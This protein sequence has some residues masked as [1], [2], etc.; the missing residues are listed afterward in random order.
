MRTL[1]HAMIP[2][3][4]MVASP[5]LSDTNYGELVGDRSIVFS[6]SAAMYTA[7]YDTAVVV[8]SPMAGTP[9]YRLAAVDIEYSSGGMSSTWMEGYCDI[10]GETM[11]GYIPLSFLAFTHQEL[12]D[13]SMLLFGVPS[14][15]PDEGPFIGV[16]KVVSDGEVLWRTVFYPPGSGLGSDHYGYGVTSRLEGSGS[17]RGIEDLVMLSFVYEACGFENRDVL[18]GWT[19]DYL[20]NLIS[21]SRMAE[22]GIFHYTEELVLPDPQGTS[23]VTLVIATEEEFDE[24][25]LEY[26][27]TAVDTTYYWWSGLELI[28]LDVF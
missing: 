5:V 19:G 11:H 17:L 13:G 1:L 14:R 25:S 24:G 22:A 15:M 6:E 18:L 2:V 12:S 21:V 4:L 23:D 7:P 20:L 9:V 28:D 16:A 27:V 3:L 8:C 10:D 26:F